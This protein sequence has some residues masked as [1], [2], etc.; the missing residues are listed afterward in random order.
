MADEFRVVIDDIEFQN[1]FDKSLLEDTAHAALANVKDR[2]EDLLS[3]GKNPDGEDLP[4]LNPAYAI[5]KNEKKGG[6][7]IIR[8]LS[9]TNTMLGTSSVTKID[10]GAEY[11]FASSQVG[12]ARGNQDRTPFHYLSD[13]DQRLAQETFSDLVDDKLKELVKVKRS[14]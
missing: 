10:G 6:G 8:D 7:N 14:V 3:R 5:R 1:P 4:P 13:D 9:L 12:K 2:H 11:G